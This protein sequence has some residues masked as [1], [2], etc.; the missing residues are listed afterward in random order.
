MARWQHLNFFDKNGKYYDFDYDTTNDIWTGDIYLPQVSTNLFEVAQIFV[1]EKMVETSTGAFKYGFP[2]TLSNAGNCKW[3]VEWKTVD[4]DVFLLF[5]FNKSF[6]SNTQS[7]LIVEDELSLNCLKAT[8]F[9]LL[10][11]AIFS[12]IKSVFGYFL[13]TFFL[14]CFKYLKFFGLASKDI[15]LLILKYFRR[16]LIVSPL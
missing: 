12:T 14:V 13:S 11:S 1:L 10:P 4:P 7:S 2:H 5:Q 6:V 16:S 3:D 15:I 9:S 8:C